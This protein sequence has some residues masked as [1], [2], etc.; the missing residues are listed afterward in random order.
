MSIFNFFHS[1]KFRTIKSTIFGCIGVFAALPFIHLG[2]Y[3]FI[4]NAENGYL[5]V[6]EP[7]IYYLIMVS[8]FYF[9]YNKGILL[10]IRISYLQHQDS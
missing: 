4:R 1:D 3:H 5:D 6:T 9:K 7:L 8:I 2:Y 10:F